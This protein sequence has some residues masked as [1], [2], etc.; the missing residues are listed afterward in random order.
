MNINKLI[1]TVKNK[2]KKNIILEDLIIE[3]KTFLHKNHKSHR[4]GK[5][6]IKLTIKS[7]EL[8]ILTKIQSTKKIYKILDVELKKYIHSIQ[9][10]VN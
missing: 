3:D 5:F 10:L 4:E 6:H 2:I 7:D 1:S 9:V 8:K